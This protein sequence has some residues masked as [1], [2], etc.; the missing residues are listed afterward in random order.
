MPCICSSISTKGH[1]FGG[2]NREGDTMD[3]TQGHAARLVVS[4]VVSPGAGVAEA[5]Q[6]ARK[7]YDAWCSAMWSAKGCIDD[8]P[9]GQ[10][11]MELGELPSLWCDEWLADCAPNDLSDAELEA[12][13]APFIAEAELLIESYD[14]PQPWAAGW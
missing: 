11:V 3:G 14:G 9:R 10:R 4:D 7:Y 1:R 8:M 2:F 13:R 6:A 12:M 5:E